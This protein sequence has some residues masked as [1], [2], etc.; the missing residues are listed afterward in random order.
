MMQSAAP[1][2]KPVFF[3]LVFLIVFL[4]VQSAKTEPD[5]TDSVTMMTDQHS[6]KLELTLMRHGFSCANVI[7]EEQGDPVNTLRSMC[8]PDASLSS[9]GMRQAASA[10]VSSQ[11]DG[12]GSSYMTRAIETAL[13]A[14]PP[15]V[16]LTPIPYVNENRALS[17]DQVGNGLAALHLFND[18]D[19]QPSPKNEVMQYFCD[20]IT[21]DDQC[22]V[23]TSL[24]FDSNRLGG[25][26]EN[27]QALDFKY[28]YYDGNFKRMQPSIRSFFVFLTGAEYG[29]IFDE[30]SSSRQPKRVGNWLEDIYQRK[31][32]QGGDTSTIRIIIASHNH[33]IQSFLKYLGY[34]KKDFGSIGNTKRTTIT[35][36]RVSRVG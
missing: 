15:G 32:D 26:T 29:E 10:D 14:F 6:V 25:D 19:N 27:T 1:I 23:K 28:F 22:S 21:P 8:A 36:D 3:Y 30:V 11:Y 34:T 33:Y 31:V 18:G 35:F 9:L 20:T 17:S 13:G 12:Y 24:G 16:T 7:A 4:N 5:S 2:L